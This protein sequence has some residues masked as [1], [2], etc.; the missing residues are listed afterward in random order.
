MGWDVFI[1]HASEDKQ[2]VVEPLAAELKSRGVEVW[3][4]KY[5]LRIGDSL[6][7][8]I[9]DGLSNSRY[10][11]VVLS[12]SFFHKDWPRKEL[13]GLV[14]KEIA[15]KKVVLPVWH[16]IKR[17]DIV[18]YS[19]ILA[20]KLAETTE[21]GINFLTEELMLAMSDD[22]SLKNLN[23]IPRSNIDLL[24]EY[25]RLL[26]S[27]DVHKYSLIFAIRL[28]KPP[29]KES[30]LLKLLWPKFVRILKCKGLT[31]KRSFEKDNIIYIEYLFEYKSKLYPGDTIEVIHP[32]GR[33]ELE[34]EFDD[35]IWDAVQDKTVYLFWEVYLD[36][37]LPIKGGI[38]FRKLNIF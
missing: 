19:P 26:I 27:Q 12:P 1:C 8:K 10:G 9:D 5:V 32:D 38:D 28:N 7:E 31:E 17:N 33:A 20:G 2:D 11:I 14:Q 15:G 24:V 34:Y 13:D 4:D 23:V 37:E 3:L 29:S 30:F 18:K 21:K 25:K 36:N 6:L 35:T 22:V 16:N